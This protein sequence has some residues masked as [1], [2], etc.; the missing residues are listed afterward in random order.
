MK[1]QIIRRAFAAA[2]LAVTASAVPGF[3]QNRL[4]NMVPKNRSGETNQDSEPTLAI[5]HNNYSQM[6]GSAF[7][8]DNLDESPMV[9][10]TAPIYVS[11]DRGATWTLAF[12]VPSLVGSQFPTGDINLSFGSTWSGAP[13]HETSWLYTGILR[14][15]AAGRPMTVL[16]AQDYL[17]PAVMAV[18]DTRTGNVD[19]PHVTSLSDFGGLDKLYVGFNNG[20]GCVPPNGR[21]ATLDVSQSATVAA[22]TFALDVI[23]ARNTACQDGFAQVPAAHLDGTVYAAFIGDWSGSPRMV[24]VRDDAWGTSA[25]P[26]SI[27]TDPTDG[28]AGRFLSPPPAPALTLPFGFMGQNRLGA[29][30]VSI[31]VDPR[32]SD[33]VYVAYGDSNGSN[34][35]AIHVRRSTDRGQNWSGDLLT[36]TNAMNPE[37]AINS[38]GTVGVLYQRV[39][40]NRW[41]THVTRTTDAD[42]TVF[43][44]PGVLLANTDATAPAGTFS[45]YIGDYASLVA[46]GKN[47]FGIFSASNYPNSA[48]FLPGVQFQRYVDWGAHKLYSDAAHTT[49]VAPSIDPYFFEVSTTTSDQDFYTRDWTNDATHGD[50]GVEPSTNPVFYAT[51]DVWNRRSTSPGPFPNDQ[52]TNEDAGNGPGA[53]GKNWAFT[54]VRRNAAGA[55][56]SVTAHFLVSK[57]GTGSNYVD[58]TTGDPD[59]SFPDP[60]PVI[61][62]DGGMGPWISAP[63]EWHLKAI[64]GNHL[65]LA[66]EISAPGSP[67]IPPTL[68]GQTP[69]WPTTDLRIINDNHKAQRNMHLSTTPAHPGG[70]GAVTDYAIVHNGALFVR[71]IPL[72]IGVSGI[73]KRY[74]RGATVQALDQKSRKEAAGL[75]QTLVVRRV[76]P[77]ENRWV[78]IT[79]QAAGLPQD[80][81]AYLTVDEMAG[82][83][84]LN[85][86]GVGMR[87]APLASMIHDSLEVY[88]GVAERL[89]EGFEGKASTADVDLKLDL[90]PAAYVTFVHERLVPHVKSDL[91][92]IRALGSSDPF[93][94]D[95]SLA[96][97][98]AEGSAPQLTGKVATLLNGV[99]ARL[100]ML[101]LEKGDPAD[102]VQ[103]VR[104]QKQLFQ[105]HPKLSRLGCAP[106]VVAASS[107]FL[108]GSETGKL[109]NSAYPKLL[110]EVGG[111]LREAAGA[112]GN[113]TGPDLA[114]LEKEH[115]AYLLALSK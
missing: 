114:T 61:T 10:A 6:A 47:F 113:L 33:R 7:T 55:A 84:A 41:E 17:A 29:S 115:R 91:T 111:C 100:T 36:V 2:F 28:V 37:V 19:Q 83:I 30:N 60:D 43:D 80:A 82:N 44:D 102:I 108:R 86:F 98:A 94:L 77:G 52:P 18:L 9:T 97:A 38:F 95:A 39:V 35:E 49:E 101:Q 32:D 42:A 70:G 59:I 110:E 62:T 78:A 50:N 46:A 89:A 99:D 34:S 57:F 76:Q 68:A 58:S 54:R 103:M 107:E 20:F 92:K 104:W 14:S 25:S 27:L 51:S 4:V 79:V 96:A 40:S 1:T 48:N 11:S 16:R 8:W 74:V 53:H 5:D 15:T 3:A 45:P 22:P 31:A 112:H 71:D 13:A 56:T 21:T 12:I 106:K 72:R 73:S 75:G 67:Y 64:A 26:F 63:Y 69:G 87:T 105:G 90:E 88:R 109:T 24:V 93:G 23:E 85:G 81:S 65:C 66:V